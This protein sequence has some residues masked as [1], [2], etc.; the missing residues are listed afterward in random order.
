MLSKNTFLL[1]INLL[2]F[3]SIISYTVIPKYGEEKTFD[4]VIFL[5]TSDFSNGDTIY[6]SITIYND[7]Y[8]SSSLKYDFYE[9]TNDNK[10]I[11]GYRTVDY[12]TSS[13]TS[14][15]AYYEET[16]NYK[17]KKDTS[18]G[19][20][21]K[22]E[23]PFFLPVLIENTKNDSSTIII[24][25]VVVVSVVVIGAAIAF[26]IYFCRRCRR[27]SVYGGGVVYPSG[28]GYG[29]SPYAVQPAVVM[30][31]VVNVQPYGTAYPGNDN[32]AY[33]PQNADY[34]QGA[35]VPQGSDYRMNQGAD[36]E[37]PK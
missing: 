7:L 10:G 2:I 3:N 24:I 37:K 22:I 27:T 20:Y 33:P 25:V 21:L 29:V 23:H 19:N 1:I 30:Q 9:N 8:F 6:I 18:L 5:D 28:V 36:Y 13:Y 32:Y 35:P 11:N 31:P 17:I 14:S 34:G 4:S 16:F 12:T 26:S 15:Y